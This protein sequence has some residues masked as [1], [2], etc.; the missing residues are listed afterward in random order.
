MYN[1]FGFSVDKH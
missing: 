1:T